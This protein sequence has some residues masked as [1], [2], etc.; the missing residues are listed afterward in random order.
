MMEWTDRHCRAFHR[1]LAPHARLY[2]EMVTT[3][4]LMHG[5][6]DRLL[7]FSRVETPVALQLGGADPAALAACARMAEARGYDEVNLNL[8]CPSD[9]VQEAR[10]GACLMKEPVR[11]AECVK[12]MVEAVQ[13]PVTIKCRLG[14]DDFDQYEVLA[15][16]VDLA[17][18][19]GAGTVIVHA[20][21]ALLRGLSPAQ[22]RSIPPLDYNRVYRLKSDFPEL[23][24]V[25]NG[26][27]LDVDSLST[28]LQTVDGVMIGRAAYHNPWLLAEAEQALFGTPVPPSRR[29]VVE[30]LV[31]Y[32]EAHLAAGGRLHDVTRH[33][34][35][36]A[37]GR[38]GAR[39][40]RRHLSEHAHR[41]GATLGVLRDALSWVDE[42]TPIPTAV[43]H[44]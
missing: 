3:A 44:V 12:A 9:R 28:H 2:T 16:L 30:A 24:V 14:V 43:N 41:R 27:I 19:A 22:N 7:E 6:R 15:N 25:L 26:G 17:A 32:I 42:S 1:L 23:R 35:G 21:K 11:V 20:R 8:G 40:F 13:I 33:L 29:A 5:P 10:I 31:P 38:A 39:R 36:L 37:N 4:A 34:L 18:R